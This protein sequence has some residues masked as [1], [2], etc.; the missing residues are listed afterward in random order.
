MGIRKYL[1]PTA[2][3]IS[4]SESLTRLI[5]ISL[6]LT[7]RYKMLEKKLELRKVSGYMRLIKH[8]K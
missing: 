8:S 4:L 7:R 6:I 2:E 3:E 1:I 5:I